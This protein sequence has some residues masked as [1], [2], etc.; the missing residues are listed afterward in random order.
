MSIFW[1]K[2]R[3]FKM[4]VV[5]AGTLQRCRMLS[6]FWSNHN[7]WFFVHTS[8]TSSF[9]A[10]TSL[11]ELGY[12]YIKLFWSFVGPQNEESIE[13]GPRYR[14]RWITVS[15][16]FSMGDSDQN[17]LLLYLKAHKKRLILAYSKVVR[18]HFEIWACREHVPMGDSW[19]SEFP[20]CNLGLV[21]SNLTLPTCMFSL[22]QVFK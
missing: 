7:L 11:T 8:R 3:V 1:P 5:W 6:M 14:T 18:G 9:G 19:L 20:I 2:F 10:L 4:E 22:S 16:V 21:F 15:R 17:F 13:A 12:K